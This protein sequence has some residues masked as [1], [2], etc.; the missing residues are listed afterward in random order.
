MRKQKHKTMARKIL[1]VFSFVVFA[2]IVLVLA[3]YWLP[4]LPIRKSENALAS[5]DDNMSG[6]AWF[7]TVG[8]VNFNSTD[9]DSDEDEIVDDGNYSCISEQTPPP[10]FISALYGVNLN[11]ATGEIE[12]GSYGWSSNVGWM[13]FNPI[14]PTP[15]LS[16]G[17]DLYNFPVELDS[18]TGELR[19]WARIICMSGEGGW[20]RFHSD[21]DDAVQYGVKIASGA[22]KCTSDGKLKLEG[23]AWS[24]DFGWMS[25]SGDTQDG[26]EY[27]VYLEAMPNSPFNIKAEPSEAVSSCSSVL[28][29]WDYSGT[30]QT[31][32]GVQRKGE[33]DWPP[34]TELVCK[35]GPDARS[36]FDSELVPGTKYSYRIKALGECEDSEWVESGSVT[37]SSVCAIFAVSVNGQCPGSA[38]VSWNAPSSAPLS[39]LSYAIE[40]KETKDENG[41]SVSEEWMPSTSG[42]CSASPVPLECTDIISGESAGKK[43]YIY[44][45]IAK[46]LITDDY[47]ETESDEIVPCPPAPSWIEVNPR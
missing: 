33:T 39:N 36:C 41:V 26:G 40:R 24:D 14:A 43:T 20:V 2:A 17:I 15:S 37:T 45:V 5:S 9:C 11:S 32:F 46:D 18:A 10:P 23:Y 16:T 19:G 22:D 42:T 28:I 31:G 1:E 25:F 27:G 47:T 8:W 12:D 34:E 35:V 38:V 29:A 30:G 13:D 3:I 7:S 21:P 44:K 6:W 4:Y